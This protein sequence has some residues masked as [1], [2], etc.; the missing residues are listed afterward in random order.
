MDVASKGCPVDGGS[1]QR[2][3]EGHPHTDLDQASGLGRSSRPRP[4]P[5]A[6]EC[7]PEQ[8][9]VAD[10]LER[11]DEEEAAG[12]SGERFEPARTRPTRKSLTFSE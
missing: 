11:G 5:E 2:M 4:D 1:D 6:L 9:D 7:P 12:V 8:G 3:A 10:G